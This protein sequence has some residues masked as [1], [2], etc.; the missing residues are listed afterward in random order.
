MS[1][2]GDG[3]PIRTLAQAAAWLEGLI[4][5]EKRPDWSYARFSLAPIH[6]LLD[7]LGRPDRSLRILHIAGSKGKGSTALLAEAVLSAA[8]RRVGTFTSPHLE[9]WT[10]RFRVGGRE[11]DEALLASAVDTTSCSRSGSAGVSTPPTR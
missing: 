6:A 2:E 11:V 7:R 3:P 1:P 4:N 9:R 8:G 5:V 10:E